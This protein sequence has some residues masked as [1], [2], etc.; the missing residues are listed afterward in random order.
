LLTDAGEVAVEIGVHEGRTPGESPPDWLDAERPQEQ[1]KQIASRVD[2]I[3]ESLQ[4]L[5]AWTVAVGATAGVNLDA[6]DASAAAGDSPTG[7]ALSDEAVSL[8]DGQES[9]AGALEYVWRALG[10][11]ERY[12]ESEGT[13][14]GEHMP[15]D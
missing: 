10:G 9:I 5:E 14:L 1:L 13:S 4:R 15:E 11:F 2:R 8:P 7:A 3:D 6:V 12:M